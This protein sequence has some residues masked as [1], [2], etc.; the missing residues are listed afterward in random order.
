[1][2]SGRN[3]PVSIHPTV[4][5]WESSGQITEY[6]TSGGP[7]GL[8]LDKA[9]NVWFCRMSDDKLGKL[10]PKSGR[11]SELSTGRRSQPRRIATAPDG[12]LWV[13]LYGNDTK[14]LALIQANR[15]G[16]IRT[17]AASGLATR[18]MARANAM[19]SSRS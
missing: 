8:A 1:M 6:K 4:P 2:D 13:T 12:M 14:M 11:M 7:C 5:Q 18:L 10:D 16:Q 3:S 19:G 17:G 9:G 15:L